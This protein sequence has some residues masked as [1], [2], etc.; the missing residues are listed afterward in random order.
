VMG[1]D[2]PLWIAPYGSSTG[3]AVVGLTVIGPDAVLLIK[4]VE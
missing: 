4:Q 2:T 1:T 3:R